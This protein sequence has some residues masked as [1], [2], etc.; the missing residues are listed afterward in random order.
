MRSSP[1]R[2]L[3]PGKSMTYVLQP[4]T[5][6]NTRG[7]RAEADALGQFGEDVSRLPV[8]DTGT[9]LGDKN[10]GMVDAV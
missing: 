7:R 3:K 2:S 10:A 8:G 5:A 1:L 9:L 6:A 4:R